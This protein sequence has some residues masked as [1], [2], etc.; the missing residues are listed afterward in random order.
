MNQ[1]RLVCQFCGRPLSLRG[2]FWAD[3]NRR[4]YCQ[5]AGGQHVP[6]TKEP[7]EK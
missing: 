7:D 2:L 6:A 3:D 5:T 1:S 4:I